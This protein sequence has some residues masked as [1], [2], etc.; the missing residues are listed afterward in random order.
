MQYCFNMFSE[1]STRECLSETVRFSPSVNQDHDADQS[2]SSELTDHHK[3]YHCAICKKTFSFAI[4]LKRHQLIFHPG[5]IEL[6]ALIA[7]LV[8]IFKMKIYNCI[9]PPYRGHPHLYSKPVPIPFICR[10]QKKIF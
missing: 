7:I 9:V 5:R 1:M 6:H 4:S 3:P 10:A 8:F 2:S